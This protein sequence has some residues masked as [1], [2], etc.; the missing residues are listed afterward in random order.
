MTSFCCF[1]QTKKTERAPLSSLL[2]F[3]NRSFCAA[4]A[5]H[6]STVD[7]G[8]DSNKQAFQPLIEPRLK[9]KPSKSEKSR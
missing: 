4:I 6:S 3:R 1:K 9:A 8:C 5:F 7:G 2:G